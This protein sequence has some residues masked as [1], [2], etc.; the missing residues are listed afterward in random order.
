MIPVVSLNKLAKIV[1]SY[2]GFYGIQQ[3]LVNIFLLT[4]I[5]LLSHY[6]KI[7]FPILAMEW[8]YGN[9]KIVKWSR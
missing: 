9:K 6:T 7:T 4:E 2:F 5:I 8:K 3:R 1:S